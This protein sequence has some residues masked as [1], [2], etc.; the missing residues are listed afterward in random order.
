ME[1]YKSITITTHLGYL[2]DF[3]AEWWTAKDW[4]KYRKEVR[5]MKKEGIFGKPSTVTV[6]F[7][8]MPGFSDNTEVGV[9]YEFKDMGFI[10]P[11]QSK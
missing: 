5:R 8:E 2:G 3:E 10:I 11:A 7:K 9:G 6:L 4:R 1:G